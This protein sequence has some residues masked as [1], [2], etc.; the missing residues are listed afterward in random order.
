MILPGANALP[1]SIS[2]CFGDQLYYKLH[3]LPLYRI[4]EIPFIQAFMKRGSI[5]M[6]SANTR[7]DTH[8]C[9][10]VTPTGWL[11]LHLT[12]DT[13]IELGLEATKQTHQQKC[14]DNYVVKINL[15]ANHFK[16]G[17]KNYD[18][19]LWC[20]K[21]RLGLTFD[22]YIAWEPQQKNVCS[23]SVSNYFLD[24][25]KKVERGPLLRKTNILTSL[26][27]PKV[28]VD[29]P[30]VESNDDACHFLEVFEWM[31]AVACRVDMSA[32]DNEASYTTSLQCPQPSENCPRCCLFQASGFITPGTIQRLF[33]AVRAYAAAN[34]HSPAASLTTH[35]FR[36][37]PV[38]HKTS[39]H[40]LQTCGD[41]LMSFFY[42]PDNKCW[43]YRAVAS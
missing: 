20:L 18:S 24:K 32:S 29:D 34:P 39:S 40:H 36:D 7:L 16:P 8:N 26:P 43:L 33:E 30:M 4:I 11:I 38:L 41:N 22:F 6:L 31:G 19:T 28:K 21:N 27:C 13:Y 10:A 9:V 14:N 25:C 5:Y 37:S 1:E 2:E 17:K 35:G 3:S 42:L 12:K 15:L 23:S